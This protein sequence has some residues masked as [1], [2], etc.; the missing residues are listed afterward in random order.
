[1]LKPLAQ[2]DVEPT[3][4]ELLVGDKVLWAI[5]ALAAVLIF[6]SLGDRYLWQDEAET[7]LLG[8]NILTFWRPI[9]YDGTNFVSQEAGREFNKSD[10]LWRWSPWIQF[11]VAA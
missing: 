9:A 7:A 8:K 2:P 10:F 11:Y 1:M 6:W 3:V 5:T 4:R